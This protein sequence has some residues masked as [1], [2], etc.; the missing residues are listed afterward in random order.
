MLI[1]SSNSGFCLIKY[2]KPE[3]ALEIRCDLSMQEG[4]L[5]E[6]GEEQSDPGRAK[7]ELKVVCC[8]FY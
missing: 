1:K 3:L 5:A 8:L 2:S 4:D 7:F 6:G